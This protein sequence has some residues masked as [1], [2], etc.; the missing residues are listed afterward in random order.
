MG[1][2][3]YCFKCAV[4]VRDKDFERGKA[5]RTGDRVAC[6]ACAKATGIAIPPPTAKP[7]NS[8]VRTPKPAVDVSN[9]VQIGVCEG[10]FLAAMVAVVKLVS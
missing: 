6:A 7:G 1:A 8:T 4:L 9:L 5:V 3:A 2:F 10:L